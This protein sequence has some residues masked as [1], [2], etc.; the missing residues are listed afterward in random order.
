MDVSASFAENKIST[1]CSLYGIKTRLPREGDANI[2]K[3]GILGTT[4]IRVGAGKAPFMDAGEGN[5]L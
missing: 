3:N 1:T 4:D 5:I 2:V